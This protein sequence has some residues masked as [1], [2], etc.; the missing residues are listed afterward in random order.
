M[1]SMYA[2]YLPPKSPRV[3]A[4]K[5]W[6][7][8]V[9]QILHDSV[10]GRE[11]QLQATED[12]SSRSDGPPRPRRTCGTGRL[13]AR[14]LAHRPELLQLPVVRKGAQVHHYSTA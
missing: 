10:R 8:N 14:A 1:Y 4:Q 7:Y 6:V 3:A 12:R 9:Y 5:T 13:S 11:L 2:T